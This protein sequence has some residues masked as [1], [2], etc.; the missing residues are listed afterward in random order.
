ME[1]IHL[2]S[3]ALLPAPPSASTLRPAVPACSDLE[4]PLGKKAQPQL[5]VTQ[6]PARELT[7]DRPPGN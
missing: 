6:C 1:H 4:V 3:T 7:A 2:A 5:P